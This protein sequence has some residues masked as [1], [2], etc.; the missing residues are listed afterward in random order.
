MRMSAIPMVHVT[1]G[2]I[3]ITVSTV[4]GWQS[5]QWQLIVASG[6]LEHS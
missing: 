4:A 3:A 2:A 6:V 5:R 1:F